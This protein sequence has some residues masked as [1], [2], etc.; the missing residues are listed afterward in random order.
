MFLVA[1]VYGCEMSSVLNVNSLLMQYFLLVLSVL[2]G[3]AW[4]G[5][6][7]HNLLLTHLIGK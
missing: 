1:V 6:Q 4:I 5:Q 7:V 2:L 3:M